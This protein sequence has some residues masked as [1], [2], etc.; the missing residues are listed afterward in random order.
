[1]LERYH[2]DLAL[3]PREWPLST[4]LDREPGWRLIYQ[5]PLAVLV[6]RTEGG[7]N[8]DLAGVVR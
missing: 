8:P 2:F 5:D 4:V 3:L 1:L 6:E 7:M